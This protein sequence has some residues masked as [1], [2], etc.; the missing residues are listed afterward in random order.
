M[1]SYCLAEQKRPIQASQYRAAAEHVVIGVFDFL[2]DAQPALDGGADLQ[3][4]AAGESS[5]QRHAGQHH[6][7]CSFYLEA[8]QFAP[9]L[10]ALLVQD[11]L[12]GHAVPRHLV[13]RQVDAALGIV[14]LHVLPEIDELKR[15]AD[16]VRAGEIHISRAL[17]K[18]QQQAADRIG[19]APAGVE[20]LGKIRVALLG[21]VLREC[22]EQVLEQLDGKS[23][24]PDEAC[25]LRGRI[26]LQSI[27]SQ[28]L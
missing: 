23:V 4:D 14:D 21:D 11:V 8:H 27:A 1:I 17:E 19:G 26:K 9:R 25:Q 12:L 28:F 22:I 7:S 16:R 3:A 2:Q 13:L 6:L 10:I 5:A 20:Q 24:P 15:R 18:M